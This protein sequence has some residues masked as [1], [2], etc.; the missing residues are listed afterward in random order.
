MRASVALLLLLTACRAP[1]PAPAPRTPAQLSPTSWGRTD[2][3]D[4]PTIRRAERQ[5][6]AGLS[7][8]AVSAAF[9]A[10]DEVAEALVDLCSI[11]IVDDDPLVWHVWC[12]SDA[13]FQSGHYLAADREDVACMGGDADTAFECIGRILAEHLLERE[14]AQHV[15]G[16]EIVSIGSVDEQRLREGT[17]FLSDAC[18]DL[19][20]EL[21]LEEARRWEAP[22]EEAPPTADE[23][24][25]LWNRRLSWCRAA[26]AGREL[27]RGMS[28]A[29][30]GNYELAP[31]G[32]GADWLTSWRR[33]H[34]RPCPTPAS[35]SGERGRGQCRDARRVDLYVR[36]RAEQGTQAAEAC[37]PP[38]DLTGGEAGQALYC[39]ADC[40]ARAATGRN[41]QGF[42]A[43]S[44]PGDLLYADSPGA[45][46]S[47]WIV[48]RGLGGRS[49]N[50]PS[51]RRLLLRE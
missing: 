46:P 9:Q 45:P 50:T 42:S 15:S 5:C 8:R 2:E 7:P 48:G 27:R 19:Q 31:I 51:V 37:A 49:V 18:V 16:V 14:M 44:A 13:T 29:I 28:R 10:V 6:L 26:F 30:G 35:V 21:S 23:R 24:A 25:G 36:V 17:E 47:G 3:G 32:A 43:P 1:Y 39:Y 4:M 11:Q 40:Q 12:G 34:G 20:R 41:P 33:Q 38:G 22:S